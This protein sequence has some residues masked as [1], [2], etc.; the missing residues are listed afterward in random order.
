MLKDVFPDWTAEDLVFALQE[1]DGDVDLATDRI[2]TGKTTFCGA[3][4]DVDWLGHA[5]QWG[6]VK[7]KS[8]KEK[9][10]GTGRPEGAVAGTRGRGRGVSE[11]G[12]AERGS[13]G[14]GGNLRGS[15]CLRLILFRRKRDSWT[16]QRRTSWPWTRWRRSYLL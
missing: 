4:G 8:L 1:V 10:K 6:Q 7:K 14:R 3:G 5:S 9:P 11:R 13:R 16:W 2:A 12:G 15:L